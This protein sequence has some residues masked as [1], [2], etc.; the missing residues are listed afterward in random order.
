MDLGRKRDDVELPFASL[1]VSWVLGPEHES[2]W[3]TNSLIG[4]SF[5]IYIKFP[6]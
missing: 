2:N 3:A 5:F 4:M 6:Y 1:F